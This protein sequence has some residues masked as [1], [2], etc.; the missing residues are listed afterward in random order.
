MSAYPYRSNPWAS[1]VFFLKTEF[2]VMDKDGSNLR[3]I[4][5]FNE[6][7]YS[8]FSFWG[9]VAANGVWSLD[10]T[11]LNVLALNFPNYKSWD[12]T[13]PGSCGGK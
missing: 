1:S 9:S 2:M 4:S 5:H 11:A 7:G 3:Q 8:E 6:P 10:G 13:F 12:I